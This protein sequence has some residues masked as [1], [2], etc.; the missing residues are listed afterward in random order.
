MNKELNHFLVEVFNDILKAEAF[1]VTRSEFKNLSLRELHVI[2][3]VC[4]AEVNQTD[5]RA[6]T[7]ANTLRV[8]AGTL[9]TSVSLLEKKGYL[10]RKKDE[11]DK[12]VVRIYSTDLGKAA[13]KEHE[14]FHETMVDYILNELTDE[15]VDVFVKS[16]SKVGAFFGSC[17]SSNTMNDSKS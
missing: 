4:N 2:E 11:K 9:T 15:E 17:F 5:N 6:T 10:L 8:T 1:L 3:A 12:R 14:Y 13:N 16:L 7:I